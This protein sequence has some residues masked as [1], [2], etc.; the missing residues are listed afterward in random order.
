MQLRQD[1]GV[2]AFPVRGTTSG[3]FQFKFLKYAP[4]MI[5]DSC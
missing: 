4:C 5:R 2:V 3:T 1:G